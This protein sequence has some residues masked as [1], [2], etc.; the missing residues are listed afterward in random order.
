MFYQAVSKN[1]VSYAAKLNKQKIALDDAIMPTQ[2][3]IKEVNIALLHIQ[4][5]IQIQYKTSAQ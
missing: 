1:L 5:Y 3:K 4:Q 2:N